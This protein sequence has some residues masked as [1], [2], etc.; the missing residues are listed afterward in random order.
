MDKSPF[1]LV[2]ELLVLSLSR[3]T[4]K[5]N[6]KLLVLKGTPIESRAKMNQWLFTHLLFISGFDKCL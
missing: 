2:G 6:F 1:F 3:I 4:F 5:A